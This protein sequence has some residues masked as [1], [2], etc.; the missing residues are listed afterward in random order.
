VARPPLKPGTYGKIST[1]KEDGGWRAEARFC[2][3]NG[4]VVRVRRW[5]PSEPKAIA[6]LK[7]RMLELSTEALGGRITPDSRFREVAQMWMAELEE[8]AAAGEFSHNSLQSYRGQL[9]NRALPALGELQ[10]R[11]L[12]VAVTEETVKRARQERSYETAAKVKVVI[13][14]VCMYAVRHGAMTA[15][16]TKSFGRMSKGETQEVQA[17]TLEQRVDLERKLT[18]FGEGKRVTKTGRSNVARGRIWRDLPDIYAGMLATGSR[19]GEIL[20]F[21]GDNVDPQNSTV[22]ITHHLVHIPKQG[23][24]RIAKRKNGEPELILK[25]PAWSVPMWRRRKLASGGGPLF[26]AWS[27]GWHNPSNVMNKIREAMDACGYEWVTSHVFRKTVG[28]VLD[29]AGLPTTAIADQLGNTREV[30]E[31]HYRKRRAANQE[32]ADVL[33]SMLEAK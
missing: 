20:A 16:P 6:A 32:Q 18:E 33:E 9:K 15:D 29:E 7:D 11:E 3:R 13:S 25:V 24:R 22:D 19:L 1:R 26:P 5:R 14:G 10:M 30:A 17:L 2:A 27:G 28:T 12:D 23:V 21:D 4:K 31:K 8:L